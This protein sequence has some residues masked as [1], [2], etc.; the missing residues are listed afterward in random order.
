MKLN[1]LENYNLF[2]FETVDSTNSEALRLA[3]KRY[4][5]N[6]VIT[7]VEQTGGRASK[8]RDWISTSRNLHIS[9]LLNS[10]LNIKRHSELS[11]LSANALYKTIKKFINKNKIKANI[12]LKWP[13]D[14]LINE[15]KTAGILVESIS[16]EKK[17]YAIIGIGVNL[18]DSPS[19]NNLYPT[20][21]LLKEGIILQD[22]NEFLEILMIQF[23]K[24][25]YQWIIDGNF[26][27]TRAQW[28][29]YAYRLNKK[30][31][32][33]DGAN[34]MSGIFKDIDINGAIILQL[35]DGQIFHFL[36]GDVLADNIINNR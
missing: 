17:N 27:E 3:K 4:T 15:K 13:N 19:K 33:N 8:G 32:I 22:A 12:K 35:D 10:S 18:I 2:N 25:Y 24:L 16:F 21:S 20:T 34:I 11:F 14:I 29:K 6:C 28:L 23:N 1:W 26:I 36:A 30:I 9:I 7:A 5:E 31:V